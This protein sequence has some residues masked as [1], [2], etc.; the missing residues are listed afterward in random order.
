MSKKWTLE[1]AQELFEQRGCK[2]LETEYINCSTKMR[3]IATCGHEHLISLNN[4][5]NGKGDLCGACRR[6]AN[7]RSES[8][9]NSEMRELFEKE[10]CKVL[11][12]EILGVHQK[13][14][15]LAQCG[16]ENEISYAKFQAGG[17][18]VCPS[19]SRSISYTY[20]FVKE[21]FEKEGCVLLEGEYIN[22]KTYM[23][24]IAKC[25]HKSKIRFDA[26]L[27]SSAPKKCRDCHKHTY[28]EEVIDRN[29][30]A[31]KVWRK[32]VYE[33]DS[34]SCQAC[35]KHGGD[36]NAHHLESYDTNPDLRFDVSNGITLCPECHT[37]FH[38]IYG[39]GGTTKNQFQ[40]WIQGIPR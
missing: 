22:C 33:R 4:F 40:T 31:S 38:R 23:R 1:S 30:T 7:A 25:G 15:Y 9:S 24:Y 14:R 10:G 13:V 6:K 5:S 19:C 2:L 37:A 35:G 26:F 27:N 16:H 17:G 12:P 11:T 3:Y 8:K 20:D 29:R 34:W 36:L 21:A 18:R 28:H 39:F 32:A